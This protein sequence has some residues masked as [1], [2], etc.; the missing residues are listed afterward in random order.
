MK[1]IIKNIIP[2]IFVISFFSCTKNS[3]QNEKYVSYY[4]DAEKINE[5]GNLIDQNNSEIEF[6]TAK[7]QS[8]EHSKSGKYSLKSDEKIKF[9]FTLNLPKYKPEQHYKISIWRYGNNENGI[10]IVQGD[11]NLYLKDAI[12]SEKDSSGWE[13]LEIDFFI[14][15]DYRNQEIRIYAWNKGK[16]PIYFDDLRI[17]QIS[18]KIN[19]NFVEKELK[20]I[21]DD[22]ELLKLKKNRETALKEGILETDDE[23]WAKA[24]IFYGDSTFKAEVRLKGDW[25]DHIK[26][27]KWSFRI[28]LKKGG[29]WKGM[30]TFSVQTPA[31]RHFID[32]WLI[33]KILIKEGLLTTRYGFVPVS[34]NGKSLGYYSYEEH[35]EKQLVESKKRREGPILKMTENPFWAVIKQNIKYKKWPNYPIY[36]ASEIIPFKQNKTL[37]DSTLKNEFFV[38]RNLL[39]QYKNQLAPVSEI[40]DADK[41]AKY[42]AFVSLAKIFHSLRWHNQRFYYD[43]VLSKLEI[44]AFDCYVEKGAMD[45]AKRNIFGNFDKEIIKNIK[46]E[47]RIEYFLFSDSIFLS[48]YIKYLEKFSDTSYLNETFKEY[49][50]EINFYQTEIRKEFPGYTFRKNFL[51]ENAEN[52]RKD[53]PAYT[54]KVVSGYFKNMDF[55]IFDKKIYKDNYY[56]DLPPDFIQVFLEKQGKDISTIKI[57]NFNPQNIIVLGSKISRNSENFGRD[58]EIGSYNSVKNE[59]QISFNDNNVKRIYFRIKGK[60]QIYQKDILP[61]KSPDMFIPRNEFVEKNKFNY[62]N[63]LFTIEG[64]KITFKKGKHQINKSIVIPENYSV[65]IPAGT[66]IDFVNHAS[67]MS[68]STIYMNGTEKEKI[69]IKSSDKTAKG[70]TII[71]AN[72]KC[73]LKN[74]IFDGFNTFEYKAWN[75][76]G[77]INFYECEVEISNTVF[78]NN[79]CEDMLNIIRSTFYVDKCKFENTFSDAFDSD[80]STGELSNS[81]FNILGNDAIDFSGSKV[82]IHDCKF[83]NAKDKGISSGEVSNLTVKNCVTEN[84]NFAFVSKDN[85]KLYIENCKAINTNYGLVM[86]Q[87]K[88]EYGP[89]FINSKNFVT[90][91]IKTFMLVEINSTLILDGKIIKGTEKEVAKRF[92]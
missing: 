86:F 60:Q 70:F 92:Y 74:V 22:E 58:I 82:F 62:L 38:A 80:F 57:V 89:G 8:A 20:I 13:K 6:G 56:S 79:V 61:W 17:N 76:T 63:K 9:V 33:H 3:K 18:E 73:V 64:N 16:E 2:L 69:I 4:C 75:L 85:S 84:A 25:L 12:S 28:E 1:N 21:I 71:K 59:A 43:P 44:I 49:E 35:F 32:E 55:K 83:T 7:Y 88:P 68:F 41:F 29:M 51:Y 14:P 47:S 5:T 87:K 46:P 78:K 45:W 54:Q 37:K 66:E 65:Y 48:K 42:Q 39:F 90:S 30:K 67:F 10:L 72:E 53:L 24:M 91:G 26:G 81:A 23:S 50:K 15:S 11:K 27:D 36:E 52:I 40:F 34:L 19:Y 77:A 31:A